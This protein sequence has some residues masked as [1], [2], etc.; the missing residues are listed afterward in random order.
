M[1]DNPK[2][3]IAKLL[4][5]YRLWGLAAIGAFAVLVCLIMIIIEM[6]APHFYIFVFLFIAGVLWIAATVMSRHVLMILKRYMDKRVGLTEFLSTHFVVFLLPLSY[7]KV[8]LEAA[9]FLAQSSTKDD[10]V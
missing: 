8:K 9:H 4:L 2:T 6:Q 1:T 7:K 5:L 10:D 3:H